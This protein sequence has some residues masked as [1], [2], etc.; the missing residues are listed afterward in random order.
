MC[1]AG[2]DNSAIINIG[3][4]GLEVPLFSETEKGEDVYSR[5][6][7]RQWGALRGAVIEDNLREGFAIERQ[8]DL[9][10]REEGSDPIAK[11]QGEA[12]DAEDVDQMADMQVVEEALDVKKEEGSNS[13]TLHAHLNCMHHAQYSIRSRVIVAGP[14]LLGGEELEARGIE[15]DMF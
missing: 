6:D 5:Q 1:G 4:Q 7:G 8:R 13:A 9:T 3:R 14:K 11:R 12:E 15:E 10:I 2:G